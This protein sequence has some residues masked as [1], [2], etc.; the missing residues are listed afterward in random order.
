MA[1]ARFAQTVD[2]SAVG[3]PSFLAVLTV[4]NVFATRRRDGIDVIPITVLGP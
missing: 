3:Q 2:P 1:S 4:A